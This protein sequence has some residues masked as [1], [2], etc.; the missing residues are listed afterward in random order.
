MHT[1]GN[2]LFNSGQAMFADCQDVFGVD[3]L[4]VLMHRMN[5]LLKRLH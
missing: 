3:R 4:C 1:E 2:G 5:L